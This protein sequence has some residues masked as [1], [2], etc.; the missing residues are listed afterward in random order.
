MSNYNLIII[1]G[2]TAIGKTKLACKLADKFNGEIISADSRQVYKYMDLGTGK[3]LQDYFVNG[4]TIKYYMIDILN[5]TEEFDLFTFNTLFYNYYQLITK[6]NKTPFL[7]GGSFL[8]LDSIISNYQLVKADF[9]QKQKE[10]LNALSI[11]ELKSILLNFNSNLHNTT[12]LLHKER[13]IKAIII[14]KAKRSGNILPKPL[15]KPLVIGVVLP[16]EKIKERITIRLK[17][18][19][20]KGMIEE[21]ENLLKMGITI[22]KL[23]FFGL[24]YK[25]LGL[26]LDGK[27]NYNDMFQKLNSAIY[28]FA[29]KQIKWL[30]KLERSGVNIYKINGPNFEEASEIISRIYFE[31]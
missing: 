18:R 7:V 2:P 25:Y 19:L 9:D 30:R 8:Y 13:I 21:V 29:R 24:E 22:N 12:D 31:K 27:L 3:D 14:E 4:K 6:N 17:E 15:I 10:E 5:P 16:L 11:Q 1:L 20:Q 26:Y 23:L 28:E